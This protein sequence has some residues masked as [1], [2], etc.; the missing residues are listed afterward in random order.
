MI[1][2]KYFKHCYNLLFVHYLRNVNNT[3]DVIEQGGTHKM[4]AVKTNAMRLLEKAKIPY[5]LHDF[6]PLKDEEELGYD[7]ISRRIGLPKDQ[8]FKTILCQGTSRNYCVLVIQ[9]IESLDFKKAAKVLNEK[10]IELVD[11]RD[12]EKITGYVRGGCSPVGMK[13][14]FRTVL[15]E[16]AQSFDRILISAG[17]RGY[18]MEV[19]PQELAELIGARIED[20]R[21]EQTAIF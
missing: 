4:K 6:T 11:V 10:A 18:Q 5:A 17:K 19:S 21:S 3:L 7:E 20:I 15:D 16:K 12:L 8:I 13:K 14:L 1:V 9:G 2:T